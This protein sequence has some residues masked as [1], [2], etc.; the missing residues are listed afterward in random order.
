[1]AKK[2]AYSAILVAL[3]M[4]FSYVEVLIPFHFGIP[5]IK[6]GLANLVVVI[7]LYLLKPSQ[8]FSISVVR[9]VLV[10]FLFGSMPSMIYSLAG[11]VLSFTVML[12]LKKSKGFSMM[13]ISIAGGVS[14]NVGQLLVAA[15]VV[16]NM[17]VFYYMPVLLVAGLITGMLIGIV[18]KKVCR[19]LRVA[20]D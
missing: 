1:M 20:I 5:G 4:I 14:H 17:S 13:G 2:V 15:I 19:H 7:A 10:A 3:A 6:L 12:L 11:G 18:A 16:E 8:A 9:I